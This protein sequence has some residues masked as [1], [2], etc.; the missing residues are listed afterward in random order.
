MCVELSQHERGAR[1]TLRGEVGL[2]EIQQLRSVLDEAMR[3]PAG[4]WFNL[5]ELRGIDAS[6]VQLIHAMTCTRREGWQAAVRVSGSGPGG[7]AA[8]GRSGGS[9]RGLR[10]CVWRAVLPL[11]RRPRLR[12]RLANAC[13]KSC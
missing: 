5:E 3:N 12:W 10:A 11:S 9:R 4:I 7:G 2:Q 8:G 13:R 6:V 1:V